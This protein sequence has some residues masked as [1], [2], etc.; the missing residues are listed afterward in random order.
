MAANLIPSC[1]DCN[2]AKLRSQPTSGEEQTLHPYFDDVDATWLK[3][4]VIEA[5]P[6]SLRFFPEAPATWSP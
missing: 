3:A 1:G 4:K 6:P 2:K 5:D